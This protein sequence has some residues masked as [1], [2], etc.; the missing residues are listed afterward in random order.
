LSVYQ[1]AKQKIPDYKFVLFLPLISK[2]SADSLKELVEETLR[3]VDDSGEDK[4]KQS[5]NNNGR[6]N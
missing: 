5:G 1:A 2:L 3:R 6:Y 4:G